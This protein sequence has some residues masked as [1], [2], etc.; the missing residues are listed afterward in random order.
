M[1]ILK[2]MFVWTTNNING[3]FF[4]IYSLLP[5]SIV[6]AN[7]NIKLMID[8]NIELLSNP[9]RS[10]SRYGNDDRRTVIPYVNNRSENKNLAPSSYDASKSW[11]QTSRMPNPSRYGNNDR[12]TVI[13]YV[14]NRSENKNLAPSSYDAWPQTSRMPNPSQEQLLKIPATGSCRCYNDDPF[15]GR[16]S[17][18]GVEN[19]RSVMIHFKGSTWLSQPFLQRTGFKHPTFHMRNGRYTNC[20]TAAVI[21]QTRH[22]F[23]D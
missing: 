9:Y 18:S 5:A 17:H 4:S 6:E 14:N 1:E 2:I 11:P 7:Q 19:Y 23:L 8:T 22:N 13:P 10:L 15:Q 12:R 21:L 20:I 16:I 3:F